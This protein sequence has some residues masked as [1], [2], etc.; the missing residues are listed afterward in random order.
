MKINNRGIERQGYMCVSCG[1]IFC[2]NHIY[3]TKNGWNFVCKL[4]RKIDDKYKYDNYF[5][6]GEV[7][8]VSAKTIDGILAQWV[9]NLLRKFYFFLGLS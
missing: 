2:G 9:S 5:C 8:A 1:N 6:A 4:C 7:T 3:S